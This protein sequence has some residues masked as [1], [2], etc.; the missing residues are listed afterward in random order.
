[1]KVSEI[2]IFLEKNKWLFSYIV[3]IY[4]RGYELAYVFKC[5]PYVASTS[6]GQINII[7]K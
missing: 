4:S 1:M 5:E 7:V 3:P 6:W 2:L